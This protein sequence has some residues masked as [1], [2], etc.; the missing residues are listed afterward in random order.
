MTHYI[1]KEINHA[2]PQSFHLQTTHLLTT[3]HFLYYF[4]I[5]ITLFQI[6]FDPMLSCSILSDTFQ[7][8]GL[9]PTSLLCP[10][11]HSSKNTGV[12]WWVAIFL[13]Q[14]IFLTQGS[15]PSF[16]C[17]LPY[18]WIPYLLSHWGSTILS[19]LES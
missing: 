13:F 14:G 4:T 8:F 6:Q 7:L 11:D 10:W 3:Q 12:G 5:M 2:H 16:L 17:L 1:F 15:N 9:E 18:R 19:F